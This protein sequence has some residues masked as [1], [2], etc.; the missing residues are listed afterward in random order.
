MTTKTFVLLAF[1][2]CIV[3][4]NAQYV[5][6]ERN[7]TTIIF[8]QTAFDSSAAHDALRRGNSAIKGVAF[9]RAHNAFSGNKSLY[10]NRINANKVTVTLF[11]VTPYLLEFLELKKK[12]QNPKKLRFV[13]LSDEAYYYRLTAVTNSVG[14]FT[15][16][17][18]K[19]GKYYLEALIGSSSSGTYD[20]AVG[21]VED[22]YGGATIYQS[23]NFTNNYYDLVKTFVEIKNDGDVVNIKLH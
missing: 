3:G 23:R 22:N 2:F 7:D 16:P 17:H 18:L 8:P 21:S 11:P 5:Q 12:K 13:Y 1:L 15:F 20:K 19:P 6:P 4:A 10:G 14:E 9:T